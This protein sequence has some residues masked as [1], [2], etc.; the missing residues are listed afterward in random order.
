MGTS[1]R[2][3]IMV[4]EELIEGLATIKKEKFFDK[5]FADMYRYLIAEGLKQAIKKGKK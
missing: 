5:S 2:I 1:K 4:D 3:S